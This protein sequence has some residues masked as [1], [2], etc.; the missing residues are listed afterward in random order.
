MTPSRV[1]MEQALYVF[2]GLS[3]TVTS[4]KQ[5][6]PVRLGLICREGGGHGEGAPRADGRAG[7][8]VIDWGL[9]TPDKV[10]TTRPS[11]NVSFQRGAWARY[12]DP[13]RVIIL[14]AWALLGQCFSFSRR[15]GCAGRQRGDRRIGP[16]WLKLSFQN[17]GGDVHGLGLK[18]CHFSSFAKHPGPRPGCH[19]IRGLLP[20]P[21]LPGISRGR[22]RNLGRTTPEAVRLVE[23]W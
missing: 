13:G 3:T 16:A 21:G 6:A 5:P 17:L 19:L 14:C 10:E 18:I 9:L 20:L 2:E 12:C 1:R 11:C 22:L 4:N 7:R 8:T 15:R 23:I